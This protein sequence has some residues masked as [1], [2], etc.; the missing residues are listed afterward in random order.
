MEELIAAGGGAEP[1]WQCCDF[2][3]LHG[4]GVSAMPIRKTL[5]LPPPPPPPPPP[6]S[7]L[8]T[9]LCALI[10]QRRP[11]APPSPAGLSVGR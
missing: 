11:A 8:D 4:F 9:G 7:E 10:E 2:G 5:S 6:F 1:D 3:S